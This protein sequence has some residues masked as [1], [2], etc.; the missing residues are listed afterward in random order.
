MVD[1]SLKIIQHNDLFNIFL[2]LIVIFRIKQRI[3]HST[4]RQ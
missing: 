4:V 1:D 2:G 3:V